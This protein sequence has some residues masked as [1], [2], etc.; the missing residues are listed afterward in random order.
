MCSSDLQKYTK[1]EI[2]VVTFSYEEIATMLAQTKDN[3]EL[4]NVKWIGC[5]GVAKSS[6]V[7]EDVPEKANRIKLYST[8][9]E[10]K[11]G[12]ELEALNSTYYQQMGSSPQSY[13]MNAYDATW[14]LA[15]SFAQV[16]DSE[17]KF[18]E[19]AV[20]KAMPKVAEE[21][22]AGKYGA[23]PVSGEVKLNEYND[24]IGS[25]YKIYAVS[26]GSW[27]EAGTWK[28]ATNEIQWS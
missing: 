24:R 27:K 2:A 1:D 3:S 14:V 7:L 16:Y 13:G 25:E 26:D 28:F 11:G 10:T 18:D 23:Y 8:V 12:K 6:K 15:M 5:D 4:L 19:A 21:Y 9:S 20:A 22:S 17:N